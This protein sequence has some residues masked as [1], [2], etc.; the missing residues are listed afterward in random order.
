MNTDRPPPKIAVI[1]PT[2]NRADLLMRAVDS[3]LAQ[4]MHEFE[5]IV[6]DD[7]ST[8]DTLER[9][10]AL[11]D[12]RIRWLRQEHRGAALARNLGAASTSAE[13]LTFLDSDDEADPMWL[14][15][16][17]PP[18]SAPDVGIVCAGIREIETR[19]GART[20]TIHLPR[21]EGALYGNQVVMFMPGAFAL[22]RA[23]FLAVGGYTDQAAR[24][25]K[26][27]GRKVTSYSLANGFKL[28]S[29]PVPLIRWHQ[30]GGQRISTDPQAHYQGTL[31]VIANEGEAIRTISRRE[32][33]R[34]RRSAAFSAMRIDRPDEAAGHLLQAIRA[35]PRD[36]RAYVRLVQAWLT[37][38]RRRVPARK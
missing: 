12:P 35:D 20:E 4:T 37:L 6:V 26:E 32:Y 11:S 10:D 22:R 29:I 7:G 1:T 17:L 9:L 16:I 13:I 21:D 18:F 25:Q 30:H 5:M 31:A 15:S 24:Q 34:L 23:I 28:V 19:N 36:W 14:S 33:A 2:Y 27:L 3:V 38:L 8:D